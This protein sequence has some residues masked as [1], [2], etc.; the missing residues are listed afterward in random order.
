MLNLIKPISNN[1]F[2]VRLKSPAKG[3]INDADNLVKKLITSLVKN[4]A[5]FQPSYQQPY[6]PNTLTEDYII[7]ALME[8]LDW[9]EPST[10]QHNHQM[11][12]DMAV[13]TPD[14]L[15]Y[16]YLLRNIT[17]SLTADSLFHF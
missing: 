13:R 3:P 15:A 1:F 17:R 7:D 5:Q 16:L 8:E 4:P 9:E 6:L 2:V 10:S 14:I 12:M 11:D